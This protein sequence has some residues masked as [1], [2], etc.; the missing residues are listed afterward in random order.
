MKR[1]FVKSIVGLKT[2]SELPK[3][4]ENQVTQSCRD[5]KIFGFIVK[6]FKI[7]ARKMREFHMKQDCFSSTYFMFRSLI[8]GALMI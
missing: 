7:S 6:D 8:K 4:T 5:V 2:K 3:W 1:H